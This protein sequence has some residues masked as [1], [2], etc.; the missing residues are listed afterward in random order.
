M[1][2]LMSGKLSQSELDL[3]MNAPGDLTAPSHCPPNRYKKGDDITVIEAEIITA[4]TPDIGP[5][6]S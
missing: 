1:E 2:K 5:M 6:S 4:D 3:V